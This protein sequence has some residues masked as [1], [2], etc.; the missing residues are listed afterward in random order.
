MF[1]CQK[2]DL[3]PSN[4][5]EDVTLKNLTGFD[6]CGFVFANEEDRYMEPINLTDFLTNLKDGDKFWI[7]YKMAKNQMSICQVGDMI[8]IVELKSHSK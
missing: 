4:G 8:T 1:S 3:L 7:K 5:Y 2:E 6:G